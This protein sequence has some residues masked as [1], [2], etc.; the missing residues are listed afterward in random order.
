MKPL[1][2]K[3]TLICTVAISSMLVLNSCKKDR[4]HGST[5]NDV[6]GFLYTTTNGEGTN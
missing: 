5:D 1:K 4:Q 2:S 3:F 6:S